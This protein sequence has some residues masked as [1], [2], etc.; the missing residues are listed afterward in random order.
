MFSFGSAAF[1]RSARKMIKACRGKYR[2]TL[3]SPNVQFWK[4]IFHVKVLENIIKSSKWKY[5]SMRARST[6]TDNGKY[7]Y[8]L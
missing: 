3:G 4:Y 1:T 5:I 2:E 6:C 7:R 8:S